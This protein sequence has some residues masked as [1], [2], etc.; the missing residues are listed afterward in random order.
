[1]RTVTHRSCRVD[2]HEDCSL[3]GADFYHSEAEAAER[4][5]QTSSSGLWGQ[6][7]WQTVI[8]NFTFMFSCIVI[9]FC[10]IKNFSNVLLQSGLGWTGEGV[11]EGA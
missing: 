4:A 6:R 2:I 11:Q 1:M 8:A 7:P 9:T 5:T 3:E 10:D